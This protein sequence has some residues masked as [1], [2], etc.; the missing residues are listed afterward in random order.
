MRALNG[1]VVA[2]LGLIACSPPERP[3]RAL[4]PRTSDQ[5]GWVPGEAVLRL[6]PGLDARDAEAI[7]ARAGAAA[8]RPVLG[9]PG[10]WR[11]TL[12]PRAELADELDALAGASGVELA[13]P[14]R[15]HQPHRVPTDRRYVEQYAHRVTH[16]EAG[17]DVETGDRAVMVAVIGTGVSL[18]H[19]DLAPNIF[20]NGREIPNDL[21]D[22][23]GNGRVDDVHGWDFASG[24][25]DPNP[26]LFDM[27]TIEERAIAS[28]ET[29]AAGVIGAVGG[30]DVGVVGVAWDVS[31]VPIRFDFTAAGS[32]EAI[33]YATTLG[34]H[35]VSM[36]Y[37]SV[38]GGEAARDP[39]EEEAVN[40]AHAAGVILVASA[41]NDSVS[42]LHFPAAHDPVI[43]VAASDRDDQRAEF[44]NFGDWI[45]VTAPG[46]DVLTTF[47]GGSYVPSSGTSFSG[48]YVAGL[49]ALLRSA[50]PTWTRDDIRRTLVYTGQKLYTDQYIG[51]RVDVG[52]ALA[53]TEP[54]SVF[55]R[56]ITP[57]SSARHPQGAPLPITGIAIGERYTIEAQAVGETSWQTLASD[58]RS[59]ARGPL[60]TLD[61]SAL[62]AGEYRLRLR[63]TGPSGAEDV[64]WLA[65]TLVQG[66]LPGW[67]VLLDRRATA[68]STVGDVDGDG[69]PEVIALLAGTEGT[70]LY[71]L[72][73]GGR[74]RPGWPIPLSDVGEPEPTL[75]V[76][77]GDLDADGRVELV[78]AARDGVLAFHGDGREA[79]LFPVIPD[80]SA[81]ALG[82]V[83]GDRRLDVV[84]LGRSGQAWVLDGRGVP[85][86]GWP[87]VLEPELG[88]L[89]VADLD[90]DGQAEVA[91]VGERRL[92]VLDG[93]ARSRMGMPVFVDGQDDAALIGADVDGDGDGDLVV[94]RDR[95]NL[96]LV[97]DLVDGTRRITAFGLE[98]ERL[99]GWPAELHRTL[100]HVM[101]RPRDR[102]S[103]SAADVDGDGLAEVLVGADDGAVHA[104]A[105]TGSSFGRWPA[106]GPDRPA[107][108][109]VAADLDGDGRTDVLSTSA[110]GTVAAFD[111]GTRPTPGFPLDLGSRAGVPPV[112]TDLDG[113]GE[114]DLVV[115]GPAGLHAFRVGR[116]H[117][118]ASAAWPL[119]RRDSMHSG[120]AAPAFPLRA[121]ATAPRTLTLEWSGPLG[122]FAPARWRVERDDQVIA[123]QTA[124]SLI[125]ELVDAD[126]PHTYGV[127]ALDAA[128]NVVGRSVDLR[129]TGNQAWCAGGDGR[130]CDDGDACSSDDTCRA[131]ECS[132]TLAAPDGTTCDDG[133][134]CTL[135]DRCAQ[136]TCTSSVVRT[137]GGAP[138]ACVAEVC[139][140]STGACGARPL[141]DGAGCDDGNAC[142]AV[143]TCWLGECRGESP[144][145]DGLTCDDGNGCTQVGVCR[146]GRCEGAFPLGDGAICASDDVCAGTGICR[147]AICEDVVPLPDGTACEDGD[148]CTLGD[149]CQG[150]A[151]RPGP[152]RDCTHG[153]ACAG[154]ST[155]N[156]RT[157][158]CV[159]RLLPDYAPCDDGTACTGWDVC[160]EGTC[161]G[162]AP[163]ECSEGELCEP[164]GGQCVLPVVE[165]APAGCGCAAAPAGGAPSGGWLLLLAA[166]LALKGRRR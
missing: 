155:C 127:V 68:P 92:H 100:E 32:A 57:F 93:F 17:W 62:A 91:A 148:A 134:A 145:T 107:G 129:T 18:A 1:A 84:A 70:A 88:A 52:R 119:P 101:N 104:I 165:L 158:E 151:C 31:L 98:G 136:G 113:D 154:R 44:S 164:V 75:P 133:D 159:T 135:V 3:A 121:R 152:P 25:N 67:P 35:V 141:A 72:D 114:V 71:V 15:R 118:P 128:G 123:L 117:R 29:S 87:V 13:Q 156:R 161:V 163:V 12:D 90:G 34:A 83:D 105:R 126:R 36:S 21:I 58:T 109:P 142:T 116:P 103:L 131:G 137:C 130:A 149:L 48:P 97:G 162:L 23:D 50:H 66:R 60:G 122:P 157:G 20:T 85:L 46:V 138:G 166:A 69:T 37:G 111:R 49:A 43:A 56:F 63:V 147:N 86:P 8:V 30:N 73:A 160:Q 64:D 19:Q 9:V 28:H 143:D 102:V 132:G 65:L 33:A 106:R 45:E 2:A 115:S 108:A 94:G 24:D 41:G 81:L 139:E 76:A 27:P 14:N 120:F 82:D 78:V 22:N 6:A 40:R 55:A 59:V 140:P 153:Q 150:A 5:R 54:S 26:V 125:D 38:E 80:V 99:P 124:S 96:D 144:V 42:D 110:M 146:A 11:V 47:I 95:R 10:W 53:V 61:T 4:D 79:A 77:L 112:V 74:I 51:T 7:A 89:L 39:L 16:A